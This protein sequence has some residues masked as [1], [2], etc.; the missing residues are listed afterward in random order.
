[1]DNTKYIVIASISKD[2]VGKSLVAS[3]VGLIFKSI[4]KDTYYIKFYPKIESDESLFNHDDKGGCYI[5]EDGILKSKDLK[6]FESIVGVSDAN[7]DYI[8]LGNL[9]RFKLMKNKNI[10][11]EL[12][13]SILDDKNKPFIDLLLKIKTYV[14]NFQVIYVEDEAKN[15]R[16]IFEPDFTIYRMKNGID[17]ELKPT[18]DKIL[19][20]LKI[21][22]LLV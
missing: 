3:A 6:I 10:I 19:N 1:M 11:I 20:E 22:Y 9:D 12:G 2:I 15:E 21:N 7:L 8:T 17:N 18:S 13:G 16:G 14:P 5:S 4:N